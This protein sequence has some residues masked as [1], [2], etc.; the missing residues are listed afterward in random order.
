VKEFSERRS[1]TSSITCFLV[2]LVLMG[3]GAWMGP[4]VGWGRGLLASLALALG[5][6]ALE[7]AGDDLA[8]LG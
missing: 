5:G 6:M 8:I 1:T 2:E 3:E 4:V 7:L